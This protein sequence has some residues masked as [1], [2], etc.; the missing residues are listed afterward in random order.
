MER[1]KS[2]EGDDIA[3]NNA[4]FTWHLNTEDALLASFEASSSVRRF[5][6]TQ[7][8]SKP[9]LFNIQ[10]SVR[11]GQLVGV[12]GSVGSGKSS[13]LE[14]LMGNMVKLFGTIQINQS[15]GY[16]A[17]E[18]WIE[19]GTIRD[20]ILF[21][22]NE[23][24]VRLQRVIDA[25]GLKA[26][27]ERMPTKEMTEVGENG[28]TLSRGQ[29]QKIALARACYIDAELYLLDNPLSVFD[30]QMAKQI[31][32]QVIGP[33][34]LLRKKTRVIATQQQFMLKQ[35]DYIY[36]LRNGAIAQSGTYAE[37]EE[38]Q[39]EFLQ[40]RQDPN[41]KKLISSL[42]R[43]SSLS[44]FDLS[45]KRTESTDMYERHISVG[46]NPDEV[47]EDLIHEAFADLDLYLSSEAA[48]GT[49][50][51]NEDV[52]VRDRAMSMK[53]SSIYTLSQL[54]VSNVELTPKPKAPSFSTMIN[55]KS[56][57]STETRSPHLEYIQRSGPLAM[58]LVL[59]GFLANS[60]LNILSVQLLSIWSEENEHHNVSDTRYKLFNPFQQLRFD[61]ASTDM[62]GLFNLEEENRNDVKYLII[63]I[64]L[65]LGE[66]LA[67]LVG[68]TMLSVSTLRVSQQLHQEMINKLL[69]APLSYF[70]TNS[71]G[72]ILS[73]FSRDLD[74]CD[75][76]LDI[77]FRFFLNQVLR[78]IAIVLIIGL[79]APY[80]LLVLLVALILIGLLQRLYS[81]TSQ[82][83]KVWESITKLQILSHFSAT[84]AGASTIQA[85]NKIQE[86]VDQA[87]KYLDQHN[88]FSYG[89]IVI[90]RWLAIRLEFLGYLSI[91]ANA[92]YILLGHFYGLL[93]NVSSA[94]LTLSYAMTITRSLRN[95][96]KAINSVEVSIISVRRC[97]EMAN[98]PQERENLFRVTDKMSHAGWPAAGVIEFVNYATSYAPKKQPPVLQEVNF[99][100]F[101]KEKVAIVGPNGAG[102]STIALA[103]YRLLEAT[104][105]RILIDGLDIA[106]LNLL[107]L[108]SRMSIITQDPVLFTG[109]LRYNLDPFMDK[110]ELD[111][112]AILKRTKLDAFVQ[113]FDNGL[114]FEII[115]QGENL[116]VGQ[117]QLISLARA[118]LHKTNILVLDEALAAADSEYDVLFR[119]ILEVEFSD[120]TIIT[121]THQMSSIVDFGRVIV[122]DEGRVKEIGEPKM[123]LKNKHSALWAMVNEAGL[124]GKN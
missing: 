51:A 26:D 107:E 98:L 120:C 15:V 10:M 63:F 4:T 124:G 14:A 119:E 49:F 3:M 62:F 57:K 106:E 48:A 13:L 103:L 117:K 1:V 5:S 35:C 123:L 29:R 92:L 60:T 2:P 89:T 77:N 18:P 87:H 8:S 99:K 97:F 58:V 93:N 6:A 70:E 56:T 25:C 69:H 112:W 31:F 21:Y 32:K 95:M 94:G 72:S 73:R 79:E 33:H 82:Q 44:K 121:I 81:N 11:R 16:V 74:I 78:I 122:L 59:F 9:T 96:I 105:G 85:F 40:R 80:L 90:N 37:L 114:N 67:M 42:M 20:N 111:M 41:K 65:G 91:F 38:Q 24:M 45:R 104:E 83:L 50:A 75:I 12:V 108:R 118:V 17:Q 84:L 55:D 39:V 66:C 115:E 30:S 71:L 86:Y 52:E 47:A 88:I 64:V 109:T 102:K 7:L 54:D 68:T 19:H 100:I 23:D 113:S 43:T 53:G 61:N 22:N 76:S 116:S 46:N 110:D 101:N 27:I 34:G 28:V 36:V